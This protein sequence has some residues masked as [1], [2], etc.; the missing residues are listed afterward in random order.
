MGMAA[1]T[2][3]KRPH[4]RGFVR[5][6]VYVTKDNA[7]IAIPG[8]WKDF[9]P[10]SFLMVLDDI[11]NRYGFL[12]TSDVKKTLREL[13]GI[14]GRYERPE[15]RPPVLPQMLKVLQGILANLEENAFYDDE[16]QPG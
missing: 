8:S 12:N 2:T 6:G 7:E 1:P 13:L 4:N 14:E 15:D 11:E 10:A 9:P 3:E 5:P 16:E